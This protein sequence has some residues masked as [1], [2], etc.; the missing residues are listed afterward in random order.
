MQ[1]AWQ[2]LF[3][4]FCAS[5]AGTPSRRMRR[6]WVFGGGVVGEVEGF[7]N[8]THRCNRISLKSAEFFPDG[9]KERL[10]LLCVPVSGCA[11]RHSHFVGPGV[12]DLNK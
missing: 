6:I 5:G 7:R 9:H 1:V 11:G 3:T 4:A 10:E 12:I 2:D 8:L